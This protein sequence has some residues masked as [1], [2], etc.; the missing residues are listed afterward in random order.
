MPTHG[1]PSECRH[2]LE[3]RDE[4]RRAN[5]RRWE[6][7]C[8]RGVRSSAP[9]PEHFVEGREIFFGTRIFCNHLGANG[10]V[11]KLE[12][13]LAIQGADTVVVRRPPPHLGGRRQEG[14]R[15]GTPERQRGRGSHDGE[16][17]K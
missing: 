5:V 1:K 8:A 9:N 4:T 2:N 6:R 10:S 15:H 16:A 14:P 13:A 12:E 11:L 3:K 7:R 17:E